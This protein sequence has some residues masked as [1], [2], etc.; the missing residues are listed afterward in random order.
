MQLHAKLVHNYANGCVIIPP[1]P[2]KTT[3]ATVRTKLTGE[4]ETNGLEKYSYYIKADPGG[5]ILTALI[6]SKS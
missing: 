4:T 1:P 3:M 5:L 2:K 6:F